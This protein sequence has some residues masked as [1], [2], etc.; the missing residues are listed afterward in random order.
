MAEKK[1]VLLVGA[2]GVGTMAAV[3]LEASGRASVTAVL[4]SNFASVNEHG[5]NIESVDYGALKSWK[6]AKS[7]SP[8]LLDMQI[9]QLTRV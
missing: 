2:G 6:P 5:F 3:S 9:M 8:S 4:R 1:N 7:L